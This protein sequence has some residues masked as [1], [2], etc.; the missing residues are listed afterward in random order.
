MTNQIEIETK[1]LFLLFSI[2]LEAIK[3]V[4]PPKIK[5]TII[6]IQSFTLLPPPLEQKYTFVVTHNASFV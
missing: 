1:L 5:N 3:S 6:I 4:I 2:F